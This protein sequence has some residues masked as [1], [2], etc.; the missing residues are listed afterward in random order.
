M[1]LFSSSSIVCDYLDTDNNL[2]M[3]SSY[4]QASRALRISAS[5]QN[6]NYSAVAV[7]TR[8]HA[9]AA[10]QVTPEMHGA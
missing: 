6:G 10:N 8:Y 9:L 3:H 4:A 5:L 2:D 7:A 1:I